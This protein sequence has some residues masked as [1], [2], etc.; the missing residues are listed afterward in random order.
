MYLCFQV[1]R[2]FTKGAASLEGTIQKGDRIISLNG[3]NLEG[4]THGEAVSC[5]HQ[6]RLSSQALVVIWRDKDS[7]LSVSGKQD[8]ATQPKGVFSVRKTPSMAGKA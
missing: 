1:H 5:L 2:V 7:E 6:A 3:T 4:K 8:S